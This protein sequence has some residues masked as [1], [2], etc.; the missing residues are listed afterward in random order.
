MGLELVVTEPM[1]RA[2][3][4]SEFQLWQSDWLPDAFGPLLHAKQFIDAKV[5]NDMTQVIKAEEVQ[6]FGY[7]Y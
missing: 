3:S 1:C 4:D 2:L 5:L 6:L 7:D